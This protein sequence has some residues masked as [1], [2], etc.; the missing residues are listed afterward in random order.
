MT[1]LLSMLLAAGAH[2]EL[3]DA[4]SQAYLQ[5]DYAA[6]IV[7][8]E[9]LVEHAVADP[10]VFHNLGNAYY[11][12]GQIAPA[13]ANYERA[14]MLDPGLVDTRE[15]LFR[16]VAQTE[17][18]LSKPET[19]GWMRPLFFWS[20]GI[21]ARACLAIA[22]V[23]WISMWGLLAVRRLRPTPYLRRAAAIAAL[24][25]LAFAGSY[26]NR[27]EPSDIAVA[28]GE[29]IA[30]RYGT[31]E[32]ETVHFELYNG[33]RVRVDQRTGDWAR[34]ATSDGRRGWAHVHD[35]VFVGPPFDAPSAGKATP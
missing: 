9:E 31:D 17:R 6:A 4:G 29:R 7:Q 24:G 35:L 18:R 1:I 15:N 23:S 12:S 10:A 3:F 32:S 30:V 14:L 20:D 22:L 19:A 11:R 33:D 34:V 2:D 26:L 13:I 21:S 25:A 8:F 28:N 27:T 5:G 16:C